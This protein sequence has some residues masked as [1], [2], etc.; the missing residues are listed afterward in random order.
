[1]VRDSVLATSYGGFPYYLPVDS[2][3]A[4][5]NPTEILS[6]LRVGDSAVVVLSGVSIARKSG[7]NLPPYIKR[8]DKIVLTFKVLNLFANQEE[9]M[10][11]RQKEPDLEKNRETKAVEKSLADSSIHATKTE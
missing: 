1:K 5:Y 9:M 4:T 2:P 8:K 10:A 3:R 6:M 7:G 11:D